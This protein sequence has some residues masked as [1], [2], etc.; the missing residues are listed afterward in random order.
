MVTC[1]KCYHEYHDQCM[2]KAGMF[3]CDCQCLKK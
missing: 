2:E 1:D 3:D